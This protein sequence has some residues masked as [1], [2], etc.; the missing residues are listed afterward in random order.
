MRK[1]FLI[2]FLFV[3]PLTTYAQDSLLNFY[4]DPSW[5]EYPFKPGD[6][7]MI[8]TMPDTSSILNGIYPID[9]RGFVELP[10][11][12]KVQV[13]KLTVPQLVSFLKKHYESYLRFPNVYVKPL[14]RVSLLGGFTRPGL[15]Y[16]DI[17]SSLWDL[18]Y[19][20]G[21]TLTE[22]GIYEMHWQ[23]GEDDKAGDLTRFFEN[24]VSLKKMGFQS[25]DILWT[26]SPTRRTFWDTVR[27]VMPILT[28]A[29]T[30]WAIYN[31]YQRDV[32]I[33]RSR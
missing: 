20:A 23:R 32:L 4:A 29:T 19:L 10:I 7:L 11:I 25:G 3:V 33:L 15:Y 17:N 24:G 9:D 16:V 5:G 8:S 27:D 13:S 18:V 28:F 22:D 2:F 6:G 26:P 14:V 30:I 21:G 1:L 12:G 31:T